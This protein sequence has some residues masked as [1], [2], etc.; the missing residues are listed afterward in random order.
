MRSWGVY[1]QFYSRSSETDET[2]EQIG[3]QKTFNSIVDHHVF[4][5][6]LGIATYY[7]SFNS[8]VDHRG[9]NII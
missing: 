8:I 7:L 6:C 4:H 3:A 1:F 9:Q 5:V 2:P